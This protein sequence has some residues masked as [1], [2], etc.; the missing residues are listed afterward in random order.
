MIRCP[1]FKLDT[2]LAISNSRDEGQAPK[3]GGIHIAIW[4]LLCLLRMPLPADTDVE[5]AW[6]ETSCP[7][8]QE[9]CLPGPELLSS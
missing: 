7:L 2:C 5:D 1:L 8:R 6:S 4:D 3:P 9:V